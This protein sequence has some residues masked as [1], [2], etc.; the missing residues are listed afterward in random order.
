MHPIADKKGW[1]WP[2][3]QRRRLATYQSL[4]CLHRNCHSPFL[5]NI[6]HLSYPRHQGCEEWGSVECWVGRGVMKETDKSPSSPGC[7]QARVDGIRS[8]MRTEVSHGGFPER[9]CF[10]FLQSPSDPKPDLPNRRQCRQRCQKR[11]VAWHAG[12]KSCLLEWLDSSGPWEA[13]LW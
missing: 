6:E 3:W 10:I 1:K 2:G 5:T 13:V 4:L 8:G 12:R 7:F 9:G 11:E